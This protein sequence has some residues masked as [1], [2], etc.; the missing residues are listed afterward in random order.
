MRFSPAQA[1]QGTSRGSDM[2]STPESQGMPFR[3]SR[4]GQ[5]STGRARAAGGHRAETNR[6][7]RLSVGAASAT[8]GSLRPRSRLKPRMPE[9]SASGGLQCLAQVLEDVIDVLDADG[10]AHQVAGDAGAGQFLVVEL[11]V[12]GRGRMAGQRLGV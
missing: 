12:G 6:Q 7:S 11:T 9:P 10:Q 2:G 5:K 3:W 4:V 8:M 1:A